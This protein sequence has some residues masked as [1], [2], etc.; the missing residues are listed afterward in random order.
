MNPQVE[1]SVSV[2]GTPEGTPAPLFP[3]G[4]VDSLSYERSSMPKCNCFSN[5][6]LGIG[7]GPLQACFTDFKASDVTLTRKVNLLF[8]FPLEH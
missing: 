8:H 4:R 3:S 1:V 7:S 2:P 5:G 6:P